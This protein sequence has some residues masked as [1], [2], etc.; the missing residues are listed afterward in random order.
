MVCKISLNAYYQN[1]Q[2]H[3][4]YG[5]VAP[6]AFGT[7]VRLSA[8]T[9]VFSPSLCD[10]LYVVGL[11]YHSIFRKNRFYYLIPLAS[12]LLLF[13]KKNT[14]YNLFSCRCLSPLLGIY[15]INIFYSVFFHYLCLLRCG[16][17]DKWTSW[18]VNKLLDKK[19]KELWKV[20]K[21]TSR[22]VNKLLAAINTAN[23]SNH[24]YEFWIMNYEL[25]KVNS[26]L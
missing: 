24:N 22:R 3:V 23:S 14:C 15:Y 9:S 18:Q 26:E 5:S 12:V 6:C 1:Y 10:L 17:V 21:W 7:S 2:Q 8:F 11:L 19:T 4:N 25:S 13:M 16:R 20:N